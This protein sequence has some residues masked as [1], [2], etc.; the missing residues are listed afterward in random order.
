MSTIIEI[1]DFQFVIHLGGAT[2]SFLDWCRQQPAWR[3]SM[4]AREM[5]EEIMKP[6]YNQ[7]GLS[8]ALCCNER[9]P[10]SIMHL[11][12]HSWDE[13]VSMAVQPMGGIVPCSNTLLSLYL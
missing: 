8:V 1:Q 6:E 3:D 4:T 12:S 9:Q 11:V 2:G 5:V 7:R 10:L 13:N